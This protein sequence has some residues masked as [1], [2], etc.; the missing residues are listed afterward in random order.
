MT[1]AEAFSVRLVTVDSRDRDADTHPAPTRFDV[2]LEEPVKDVTS[3][4]LRSWRIPDVFP[5]TQGRHALWIED[6]SGAVHRAA[7]APRFVYRTPADAAAFLNAMSAA[8]TLATGQAFVF[9][10]APAAANVT[11]SSPLAFAIY[12]GDPAVAAAGSPPGQAS[13]FVSRRLVDGYGADSAARALGLPR[14]RTEAAARPSASA[15]VLI[16]PHRHSLDVPET[17]YIHLAE[18]QA[19]E[20]PSA[21]GSST[22]GANGCLGI[23][24]PAAVDAQ[25]GSSL[26]GKAFHPPLGR[27]HRLSV[28]VLDYF[29][30]LLETDNAEVRLDLVITTAPSNAAAATGGAT[31][32]NNTPRHQLYD[33]YDAAA[34]QRRAPPHVAVP[35]VEMR[36]SEAAG[37]PHAFGR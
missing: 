18:A 23:A 16:A 26:A 33:A 24:D 17:A 27:L 36:L 34:S 37:F 35:A 25:Q 20:V 19:F 8:A 7:V 12:S 5:V 10:V 6:A 28:S 21:P 15:F 1:T 32:I 4:S 13:R 29:G 14:G 31:A 3:I 11:V 30:A 2:L 9:S 22:T